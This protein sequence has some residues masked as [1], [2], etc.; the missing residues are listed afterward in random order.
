MDS[1]IL[2]INKHD[3]TENNQINGTCDHCGYDTQNFEK[4]YNG[5][6]CCS[7]CF[8]SQNLDLINDVNKG[9]IIIFN[10]LS[11]QDIFGIQ[12]IYWCLQDT[13]KKNDIKHSEVLD[14]LSITYNDLERRCKYTETLFTKGA[15]NV[16]Y[17]IEYL[18][19]SEKEKIQRNLGFLK[20]MPDKSAFQKDIEHWN[21]TTLKDI[22]PNNFINI[23]KK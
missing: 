3:L 12:R 13:L 14:T 19:R 7:L 23:L 10:E 9:K 21:K 18:S 5:K 2:Q 16:D 1:L 15:S 20:W 11:Q 17:F 8:Y 6:N 22:R 4:Y